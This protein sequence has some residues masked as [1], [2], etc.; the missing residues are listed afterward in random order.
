MA[1]GHSNRHRT[2]RGFRD[3][4]SSPFHTRLESILEHY[5]GD[6]SHMDLISEKSG[7]RGP[8]RQMATI[9][10]RPK[11]VYPSM[12]PDFKFLDIWSF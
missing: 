5:G 8:R 11:G 3:S 10:F 6:I 7:F 2:G 12:I 4:R 1:F 9:A